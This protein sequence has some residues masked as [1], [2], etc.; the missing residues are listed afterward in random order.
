MP[1]N[2]TARKVRNQRIIEYLNDNP[3]AT[4]QKLAEHFKVSVNT[5]RLDR[6][7][8]GIKE[9]RER[10]K[11]RASENIKKVQ[12]LSQKE[13]IGDIIEI[14]PGERAVSVLETKEYMCFDK[15][16]VVKGYNIYSMAESLAISIIPT[17]VALVGVANIK[18]VKKILKNET[19]YATAEVKKKRDK[20]YILWVVIYN[21][22]KEVKFKSKFI[23]KGIE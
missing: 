20:N 14:I 21:K 17:K 8:L 11:V 7:R 1:R 23:L 4:D 2:D 12:S 10:V 16:N 19:L 22:E 18:Y 5:I 9:L 13:I 6:A 3:F 15:V